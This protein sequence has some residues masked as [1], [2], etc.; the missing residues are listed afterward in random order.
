MGQIILSFGSPVC[1]LV[2]HIS[3]ELPFNLLTEYQDLDSAF[4]WKV[5]YL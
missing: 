4:D 1:I 3:H 2:S 5:E